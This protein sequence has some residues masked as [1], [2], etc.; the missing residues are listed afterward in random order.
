MYGLGIGRMGGIGGVPSLA[1]QIS[2]MFAG[3]QQGAWYDPS[4]MATLFQDAAGATPVTTIE[5]PVGRMLDKSGRGNHA[6]QATAASRPVL[7]ARTNLLLATDALATQSVTLPA[8]VHT[9][10]FTGTGTVTLSG[11]SVAGPLVGTGASNRVSLTFTPTAGVLTL[12]VTG[13]VTLSQLETGTTA[14]R[15]Q[16]VVNAS[17][18]DS[19]GFPM[20]LRF[21]GVD[22]GLATAAINFS[23]TDKLVVWAGF[24]KNIDALG[25]LYES[26]SDVSGNNG[27]FGYY[28][29]GASNFSLRATVAQ[30][31]LQNSLAN[32]TNYV[33]S[34]ELDLTAA[35]QVL[36]TKARVNAG[37]YASQSGGGPTTAGGTF[38]NYPLFIGRR[39]NASLPFNGNFYSLIIRGTASSASEIAAA[40]RYVASKTGVVL[41]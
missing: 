3:S 23:A 40:E 9:L 13:S 2:A 30:E 34:A 8:T 33:S 21:D 37:A 4:D 6:S 11:V 19:I 20:Y 24:R 41:P 32:A 39:N 31:I 12:T 5:Q 16:S 18:Y 25:L 29:T 7:S 36:R 38:G 28:T 10:S 15:Y 35:T 14:T 22:D 27:S 1:A 26:S 17:T